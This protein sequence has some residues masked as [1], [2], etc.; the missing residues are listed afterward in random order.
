MSA[1]S[2]SIRWNVRTIRN[3][4]MM[5][6]WNGT[7]SVARIRTNTTSRPKNLIRA[8]AYPAKLQNSRFPATQAIVTSSVLTNH[9]ANGACWS[10][11][12]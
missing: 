9:R 12:V 10:T 5:I 6:T 8:N 2:V 3:V 1:P 7:I 4:G 11:S